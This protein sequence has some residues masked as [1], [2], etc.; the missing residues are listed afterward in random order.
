MKAKALLLLLVAGTIA[1]NSSDKSTDE[2]ATKDSVVAVV[3]QNAT[4]V[5]PPEPAAMQNNLTGSLAGLFVQSFAGANTHNYEI[6]FENGKYSGN[7][8]EYQG[9]DHTVVP[10][11]NIVVDEANKTLFFKKGSEQVQAKIAD[12]GL[13]VGGETYEKR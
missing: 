7:Y 5:P 12:G 11:E 6:K 2:A 9:A 13:E 10:L 4:T 8:E 3:D 1:C